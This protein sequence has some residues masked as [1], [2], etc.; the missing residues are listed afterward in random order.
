MTN[1]TE[2]TRTKKSRSLL[3]A[4]ICLLLA[5]PVLI[6][7]CLNKQVEVRYVCAPSAAR[8]WEFFRPDPQ[9]SVA[10]ILAITDETI[11]AGNPTGVQIGH[12]GLFFYQRYPNAA[13]LSRTTFY[14]F[15]YLPPVCLLLLASFI[16]FLRYHLI[17]TPPPGGCL[18]CGYDLRAHQ[19]GQKCPEC[20]TQILIGP[21]E[22]RTTFLGWVRSRVLLWLIIAAVLFAA[23][24]IAWSW[25]WSRPGI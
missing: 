13:G 8:R 11:S 25:I 23:Y 6:L 5:A 20:G 2:Q 3:I 17:P 10:F 18:T 21:H 4:W 22:G 9:R 1:L 16:F 24:R 14:F 19:H 7:W 15:P 12:Y